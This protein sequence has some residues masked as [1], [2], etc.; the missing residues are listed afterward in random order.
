MAAAS[1]FDI[2]E[3]AA[4]RRDLLRLAGDSATAERWQ[5]IVAAQLAMLDGDRDKLIALLLWRH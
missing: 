4:M 1:A 2:I 3:D 5:R